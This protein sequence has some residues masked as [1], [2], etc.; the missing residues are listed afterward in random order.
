MDCCEEKQKNLKRIEDYG[1]RI[2]RIGELLNA[3]LGIPRD[4]V[5][6]MHSVVQSVFA[7]LS[8]YSPTERT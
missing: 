4:D 8:L 3:G 5:R 2:D 6:W 1:L 7:G